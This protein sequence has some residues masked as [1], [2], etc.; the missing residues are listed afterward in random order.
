VKL[1]ETAEYRGMRQTKPHDLGQPSGN[2]SVPLLLTHVK[3]EKYS[4]PMRPALF[5]HTQ[6]TAGSSILDMA[7]QAY[8]KRNVFGFDQH[9]RQS[10]DA[11]ASV[12]FLSGH[13]GF[14]FAR[15]FMTDR[16]SFTFLRD[17]IERVLSLYSHMIWWPEG[18]L[19]IADAAKQAG[20]AGFLQ[21]PQFRTFVWNNQVFQLAYGWYANSVGSKKKHVED[22]TSEDLLDRAVRNLARF[23]YVGFVDTIDTDA[24]TIFRDLGWDTQ[25]V[26]HTNVIPRSVVLADLSDSDLAMLHAVT[27]LDQRLLEYAKRTYARPSP[28]PVSNTPPPAFSSYP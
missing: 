11:C 17:P 19:D 8:G 9:S 21:A 23:D 14:E 27:A 15:H 12:P 20:F 5:M 24:R 1:I 4:L 22:F 28:T 26:S 10:L 2:I 25:A 3:V 18:V 6:K 13:F 7:K 16:Y